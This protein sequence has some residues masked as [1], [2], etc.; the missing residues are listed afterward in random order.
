MLPQTAVLADA[1]GAYVFIVNAKS[2][3]ERRAVSVIDTT[4]A[5]VVIGSG[6]TGSERMVATASG[7]LREGESV[8]PVAAA[9]FG[10]VKNIS[11]WAIRHPV[12]PLVLFVVLSFVG[13]VAFIRLPI[14]EEP[15]IAFPLV[16]V[17]VG[18]P[19][20]APTEID[21]QIVQKIEGSIAT[22]S[23]I[24]RIVSLSMEGESYTSVE[25]QIGTPVDRAV[26]DVRDAVS[27]VRSQLPQ[28]VQEPIVQ[29]VDI[30]GGAIVYYAVSTTSMSE[31]QLSWFVDNTITKR[32]LSVAGVAQVQRGGGVD[33]EIR[34]DLDPARM[35]ALGITAVD[36]NRQLQQLNI[37]APG[38]RAQLGNGEQSIRVLGGA[39]SA[40]RSAT[41]RSCCPAGASRDSL[42]WPKCTTASPRC[43]S[44]RALTAGRRPRLACC[45]RAAPRM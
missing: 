27:K 24:K 31:E 15:D 26:S 3:V 37:D 19:G 20:A 43:A 36:V 7:F 39:S 44:C 12:S 29:R 11:A 1:K 6:L 8:N 32:L 13:I 35:Q 25:F 42:T 34:V 17:T 28:N 30:D 41:H 21:T 5:G 22:V 9:R 4:A 45:A 40:W 38:G 14:N 16:T 18:E 33:R 10:V 2:I 23:N